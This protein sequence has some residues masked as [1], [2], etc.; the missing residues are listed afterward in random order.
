MFDDVTIVTESVCDI[1]ECSVF[2]GV[3][4][5]TELMVNCSV[6]GIVPTATGVM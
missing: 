2:E 3:F 5:A 1:I 4:S 6:F